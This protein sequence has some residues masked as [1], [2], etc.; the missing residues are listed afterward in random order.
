[1]PPQCAELDD[2]FGPASAL[3]YPSTDTTFTIWDAKQ[4]EVTPACRVEPSSTSDVAQV[5]SI[6]TRNSCTFAIKGGGHSRAVDASNSVGGVTVDMNKLD[7]IEVAADRESAR[8]GAGLTLLQAYRGL[9]PLGL[10]N[11]GGRVSSVGV[12]GY[13]MGGGFSNLSPKMGLAVDNVLEFE[14]SVIEAV[15]RWDLA[16]DFCTAR[17]PEQHCRQRH[18]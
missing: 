18:V 13:T 10:S 6:L 17:S 5:L 9:E 16:D 3:H 4:A 2:I 14:V 15:E 11:V 7:A 12:A 8:L 1:M